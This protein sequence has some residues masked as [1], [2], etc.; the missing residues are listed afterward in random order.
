M[1]MI[2]TTGSD[3]SEGSFGPARAIL[4]VAW[5]F[6]HVAM[7]DVC[8]MGVVVVCLCARTYRDKGIEFVLLPGIMILIAAE[9]CHYTLHYSVRAAVDYIDAVSTQEAEDVG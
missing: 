8:V 5:V 7:L 1:G 2:G 3:G 4:R 6:N 9:I